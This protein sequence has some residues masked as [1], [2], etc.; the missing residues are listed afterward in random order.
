[1]RLV[2]E[3][4]SGLGLILVTS[5]AYNGA[6]TTAYSIMSFLAQAQLDVLSIEAPIQW[7]MEGVRQ[8]EADIGPPGPQI[9]PAL[10]AMVAV[11][12]DALMVSAVPDHATA[13][14]VSQ[15]ASSLLVIAQAPATSAARAVVA[16]RDLGLPPQLL[17]SSLGLVTAQ[18]L[19][20]VVCRV[21]RVTAPGPPP[22]TLQAHGIDEDEA[23]ALQ[24]FKGKGCPTCNTVG[25]RGRRAVFEALPATEAVRA[26]IENG[27]G[28]KDVER[29]ALDTGMIGIRE[30][31][32]GL[33]RSGV[34]TFDEFARLRL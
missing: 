7:R 23:R 29:A 27:G 20:R 5:P 32:L 25:Y 13:M 16:L 2:E 26:A 31:C 11:R 9:E 30:R 14:I 24:F 18:R 15:L 17:A 8:V 6:A 1:M 22:Q 34:T 3:I 21:C 12:P 19:V 4:R 10:R 33:I 28:V